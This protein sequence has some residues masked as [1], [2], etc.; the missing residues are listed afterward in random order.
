MILLYQGQPSGELI[1]MLS[2]FGLAGIRLLP[3]MN[4]ILNSLNSNKYMQGVLKDVIWR[5]SIC[6]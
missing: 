2:V 6:Y 5:Y 4:R 3:S 1:F